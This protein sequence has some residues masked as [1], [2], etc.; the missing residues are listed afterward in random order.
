MSSASLPWVAP[1]CAA[2]TALTAFAAWLEGAGGWL[3]PSLQIYC[4]KSSGR[5]VVVRDGATLSAGDVAVRLP[6]S[7]LITCFLQ[8]TGVGAML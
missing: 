1:S 7:L 2:D 8:A 5:G 4:D 6:L 3:A